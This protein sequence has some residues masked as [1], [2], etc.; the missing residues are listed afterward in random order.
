MRI[1]AFGTLARPRSTFSVNMNALFL[2]R[3]PGINANEEETTRDKINQGLTRNDLVE[4]HGVY[5]LT[6]TNSAPSYCN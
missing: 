4:D 6:A 2:L 3:P 1:L 5:P